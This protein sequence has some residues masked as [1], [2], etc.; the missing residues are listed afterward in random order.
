MRTAKHPTLSTRTS[1]SRM[2]RNPLQSISGSPASGKDGVAYRLLKNLDDGSITARTQYFN[3][4]HLESTGFFGDFMVGFRPNLSTQDVL[5]QL[6]EDVLGY[7]GTAQTREVLAFDFKGVLDN[8]LYDAILDG[9]SRARCERRTYTYV[10]SFLAARTPTLGLGD[11]RPDLI[12]LT[13]MGTLM[14]SI[15]SPT[16]FNIAIAGSSVILNTI[17]RTHH[18]Q[19]AYGEVQE[20]LRKAAETTQRY[21]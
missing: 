21:A 13:A 3:R 11:Q 15:L 8:V 19:Y 20:V 18:A 9:L 6:N 2:S 14:G 17:P 5:L 7:A 12:P 16:L 10:R 1:P 4:P